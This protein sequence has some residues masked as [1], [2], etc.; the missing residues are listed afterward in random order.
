M[1][2]SARPGAETKAAARCA[3]DFVGAFSVKD[4]NFVLFTFETEK[5]STSFHGTKGFNRNP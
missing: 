5:R 4:T 2:P 3:G 1:F